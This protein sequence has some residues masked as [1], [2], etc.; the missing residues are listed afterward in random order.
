MDSDDDDES[1]CCYGGESEDGFESGAY[2]LDLEYL[3]EYY[4]QEY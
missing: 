1:S 3:V 2:G 4:K